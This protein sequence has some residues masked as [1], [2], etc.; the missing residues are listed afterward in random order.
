V[1]IVLIC[2]LQVLVVSVFLFYAVSSYHRS[3][4]ALTLDD[5]NNFDMVNFNLVHGY[6][7]EIISSCA[8]LKHKSLLEIGKRT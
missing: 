5:F 2:D 1:Y 7:S 6:V 3:E 8:I 4:S